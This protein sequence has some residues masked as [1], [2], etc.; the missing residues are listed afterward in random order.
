MSKLEELL[1]Y[2]Q[3]AQMNTATTTATDSDYALWE[4]QMGIACSKPSN[5]INEEKSED[6]KLVET[7]TTLRNETKKLM[8]KT[9]I[10]KNSSTASNE[11]RLNMSERRITS[12][13]STENASTF[14]RTPNQ[15]DSKTPLSHK[16]STP[17][18][19]NLDKECSRLHQFED[20]EQAESHHKI[21]EHSFSH[22]GLD[23]QDADTESLYV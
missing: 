12:T 16:W 21:E 5:V 3:P 2:L 9:K 19:Q 7:T 23:Y 20:G 6:K 1:K 13:P 4:K 11:P 18:A 15:I 14:L 10:V 17:I 8:T 22:D